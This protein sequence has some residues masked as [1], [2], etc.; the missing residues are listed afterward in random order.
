MLLLLPGAEMLLLFCSSLLL[1][2]PPGFAAAV[3][4]WLLILAGTGG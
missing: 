4:K 3:A 1:P 2:M